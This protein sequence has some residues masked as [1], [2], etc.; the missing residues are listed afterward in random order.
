MRRSGLLLPILLP[1]L[2]LGLSACQKQGTLDLDGLAGQAR[3]GDAAANRELVE[4]LKTSDAALGD[5]VYAIVIAIGKPVIPA[6]LEQVGSANDDQRERVA[7]ALGNYKVGAAVPGMIAFLQNPQLKRRYI[8]AWCLG[9]IGDDAGIEPLIVALGDADQLVRKQATRSLIKFNYRATGP[10]LASLAAD[11]ELQQAGII[12][13]LGDIGDR[14]VIDSLLQLAD[15]KLRGEVFLALGKLRD[16][17]AESALI[18]GLSDPD[19]QVR[20]NAAMALGTAGS[21]SSLPPLRVALEDDVL[22][23]RE[24]SARSLSVLTGEPVD[25]RDASGAM[26]APYSVYH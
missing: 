19:W 8:A 10:L 6:L 18:A 11:N 25:Y 4:L 7:A 23:V 22:V 9:E 12:R 5:R 20:M 15:G 24:W 26:V 14:Q 17:R 1:L 21:K 2:L 13:V 16:P 3:A